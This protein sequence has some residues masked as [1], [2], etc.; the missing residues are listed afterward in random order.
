MSKVEA[1]PPSTAKKPVRVSTTSKSATKRPA[2]KSVARKAPEPLPPPTVGAVLAEK[3][4]A[5]GLSATKLGARVGLNR[6]T[7]TRVIKGGVLS[8]EQAFRIALFFNTSTKYWVDL[9]YEHEL[10]MLERISGRYITEEI[11]PL[12]VV[13]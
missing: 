2:R 7:I 6:Q 5:A 11:T 8:L 12:P 10:F 3:M 13:S 4:R 1:T 9:Q